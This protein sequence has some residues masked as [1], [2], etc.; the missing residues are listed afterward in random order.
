[1]MMWR[2][3]TQM[4]LPILPVRRSKYLPNTLLA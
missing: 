1:L 3:F 4:N 2:Y